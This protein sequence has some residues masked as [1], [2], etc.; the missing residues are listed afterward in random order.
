MHSFMAFC[1]YEHMQYADDDPDL[2]FVLATDEDVG[3]LKSL[4]DPEEWTLIETH[5]CSEVTRRYRIIYTDHVLF[6][7]G[8]LSQNI[9]FLS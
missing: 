4:S 2:D 7:P 9:S 3:Y 6:V 5:C 1:I 8:N